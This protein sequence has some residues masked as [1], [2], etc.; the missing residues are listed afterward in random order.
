MIGWEKKP[1]PGPW[2]AWLCCLVGWMEASAWPDTH[3]PAHPHLPAKKQKLILFPASLAHDAHV[4]A[5]TFV[6]I[7]L[8][9]PSKQTIS[10]IYPCLAD[11]PNRML[12]LERNL[13][14]RG[15]I[16]WDKPG[17]LFLQTNHSLYYL[18]RWTYITHTYY[19]PSEILLNEVII[20]LHKYGFIMAH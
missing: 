8:V 12:L 14:G 2:D 5:S 13:V 6:S 4:P 17:S 19:Y 15:L 10:L 3:K 11:Q 20:N 1:Q 16:S 9:H 18:T 7:K